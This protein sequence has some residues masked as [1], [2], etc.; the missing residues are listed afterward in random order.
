MLIALQKKEWQELRSTT[1]VVLKY[2]N[3]KEPT[4][5]RNVLLVAFGTKEDDLIGNDA[6]LDVLING[7]SVDR[8]VEIVA[9]QTLAESEPK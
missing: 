7:L 4:S 9:T 1:G 5:G 3:L 8:I 6:T 2:I